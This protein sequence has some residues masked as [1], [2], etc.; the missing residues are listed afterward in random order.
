MACESPDSLKF[1]FRARRL[2]T[3]PSRV[4][5]SARKSFVKM[6]KN[7]RRFL[8]ATDRRFSETH[9]SN[10]ARREQGGARLARRTTGAAGSDCGTEKD[11]CQPSISGANVAVAATTAGKVCHRLCQA[12]V[13][14]AAAWRALRLPG[15]DS[16]ISV[17][18]A[19]RSS[20]AE[21]TGKSRTSK[22]A[23]ASKHCREPNLLKARVWKLR[24]HSQKAGRA[25]K[26]HVRFSSNS[27]LNK[28]CRNLEGKSM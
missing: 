12:E 14:S 17:R 5:K 24:R 15:E 7:R 10:Y 16:S 2:W 8:H 6:G 22:H 26:S 4:C 11:S 20:V 9:S 21:I 18:I 27:I 23:S 1:S 25:S 3:A 28:F 19:C 13:F